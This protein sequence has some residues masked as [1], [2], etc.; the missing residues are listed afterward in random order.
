MIFIKISKKL[1]HIKFN[2]SN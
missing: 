1:W 2:R